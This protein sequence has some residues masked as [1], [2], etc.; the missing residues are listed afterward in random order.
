MANFEKAQPGDMVYSLIYG[1]GIVETNDINKGHTYP[2]KVHF[3]VSN[4]VVA[5]TTEGKHDKKHAHPSLF[6]DGYIQ[7][8][9]EDGKMEVLREPPPPKRKVE[10]DVWMNPKTA[11][12][13]SND[14]FSSRILY[15]TEEDLGGRG[16][17]AKLIF[18]V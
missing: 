17:K 9:Y 10:M 6:W 5:Y 16:V 8:K 1:K 3:P 18:E 13:I 14:I 11:L 2:L 15:R 12:E 4:Y 7:L